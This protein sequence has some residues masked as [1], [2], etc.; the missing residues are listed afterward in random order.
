MPQIHRLLALAEDRN[1]LQGKMRKSLVSENDKAMTMVQIDFL[2]GLIE[3]LGREIK[4][5]EWVR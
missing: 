1:A 5:K 4:R 2:S 3:Q